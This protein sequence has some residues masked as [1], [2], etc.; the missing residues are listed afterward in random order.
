MSGRGARW[1]E[2]AAY[3]GLLAL[4]WSGAAVAQQ[5]P[6]VQRGVQFLRAHA[7]TKNTGESAMMALGLLKAE[8][9]ATDGGVQACVAKI[10][11]RFEATSYKPELGSGAGTYEAAVSAM[12]LANL[13][14]EGNRP[15]ISAIASFLSSN[16]NSNG[17]WDYFGRKQGD[18]SIS[19]YALLGLWEC[20]NAGADVS[21]S[22][23][24]HAASWYMSVQDSAGSWNYHR[25][26]TNYP[27][28]LSMTAAGVGSLLICQRQLHRYRKA[29]RATSSLLTALVEETAHTD[30]RS[31]TS[32]QALNQA[33]S[34]GM[35][36]ISS[37]F[38]TG[39]S[40]IVGQTP[41]YMLYGLERVGALA[42]KQTIGRLDWYAK[43]REYIAS[44][45]QADG[46]WKGQHGEDVNTVWAML[47]LTKSTAKTIRRSLI[48]RLGA[49]T[50]LGGRELPKDLNSLTIAG[51]R[52]VSRPMNGAI[53]GM[54]LVLE[55][56]RA[57]QADTAVAGLVDRYY[58]EGPAALR[59]YKIRFRKMLS[60][61]DPGLRR[62]A[63]WALA[64]TGDLDVVPALIDTLAQ[65]NEDEDVIGAARMGLQL[66]SRKIEGPGP[67]SPSTPETRK[68]AAQAWRE[69][70]NGI[71]PLDLEGQDE[72]TAVGAGSKPRAAP[73]PASSGSSSQ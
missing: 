2:I 29:Q 33:V 72:D 18:T 69:W 26:E 35:G 16:Q 55:D 47:F 43:G 15:L 3:L 14:A 53:E 17:S 62:V 24:D 8:V 42:D 21:P 11:A 10:K 41:Y 40:A 65:P 39:T 51:G 57:E 54:L 56:P 49:G 28:T 50:L 48:K 45:Q 22:I 32:D 27:E 59:P 12:V 6:A 68:S 44:T 46:S 52:V 20:E 23:W 71:R 73:P 13:D 58:K 66:L 63:A 7:G 36:W 70:Y 30:Y 61:R 60:D 25:D 1:A 31:T 34:R 4:V 38:T 5:D 9:P 19:Q 37:H 67:V 64:H